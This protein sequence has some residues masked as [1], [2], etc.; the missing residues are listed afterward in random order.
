[1]QLLALLALLG[2]LALLVGNTAAGLASGL[3][4]G[5]ALAAAALLGAL[6]EVAG[7]DGLNVLLHDGYLHKN[8]TLYYSTN[9]KACQYVFHV[10][11]DVFV[12]NFPGCIRLTDSQ[13]SPVESDSTS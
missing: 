6:A 11:S 1:M 12:R 3:A 4:R 5:L 13:T 10:L 7:L 2:A 9:L 8:S